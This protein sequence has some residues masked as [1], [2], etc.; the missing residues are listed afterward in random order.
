MKFPLPLN[1]STNNDT[2]VVAYPNSHNEQSNIPSIPSVRSIYSTFQ[3]ASNY[4]HMMENLDVVSNADDIKNLIKM[5]YD[6]K[7]FDVILK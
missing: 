1:L 6:E 7:V 2:S 3:M 4:S 5:C